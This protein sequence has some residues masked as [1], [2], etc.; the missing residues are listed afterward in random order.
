M[1]AGWTKVPTSNYLRW[2]EGYYYKGPP[3]AGSS[4]GEYS[5]DE[6]RHVYPNDPD[7]GQ[8]GNSDFIQ[9]LVA[10]G[11]LVPRLYT[12]PEVRSWGGPPGG[13]SDYQAS[14]WGRDPTGALAQFLANVPAQY[15]VQQ[16]SAVTVAAQSLPPPVLSS[17]QTLM[18]QQ[19]GDQ[20]TAGNRGATIAP[21][22]IAAPV[23]MPPQPPSAGGLSTN[24]ILMIA[25]G[26][27]LVIYLNR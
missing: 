20:S 6:A 5:Q 21:P 11:T 18:A 23:A 7:L 2:T 10:S 17:V 16:N 9:G 3:W 22:P 27:A 1:I 15:R 24:T 14:I 8:P 26:I 12:Q 13:Y 19:F 4:E 25:A